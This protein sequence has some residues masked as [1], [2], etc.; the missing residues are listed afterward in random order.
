RGV[1]HCAGVFDAVDISPEAF[2]RIARGKALGA[3][4]ITRTLP[5]LDLLVLFSSSS[6]VVPQPNLNYAAA[7]AVLDT[8]AYSLRAHGTRVV[9]LSWGAWKGTG[10]AR[11]DRKST[12][13][14]S[15]H[16]K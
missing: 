2:A 9:S 8:I 5:D 3:F 12:R 1:V 10:M 15:S 13:L 11:E 4:N 16:V 14:N 7:N 6:S